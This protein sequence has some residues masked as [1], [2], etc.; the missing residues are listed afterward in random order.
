MDKCNTD[1]WLGGRA[2]QYRKG[3]GKPPTSDRDMPKVGP[4]TVAGPE[5]FKVGQRRADDPVVSGRSAQLHLEIWP[6]PS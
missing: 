6:L 3:E 5:V 1:I 2:V 4:E